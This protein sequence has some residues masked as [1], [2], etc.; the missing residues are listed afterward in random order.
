MTTKKTRAPRTNWKAVAERLRSA[1][2]A[3]LSREQIEQVCSWLEREPSYEQFDELVYGSI[4]PV[5]RENYKASVQAAAFV[6]EE[7]SK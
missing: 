1:L 7:M 3:N 4:L 6:R 2:F 5:L